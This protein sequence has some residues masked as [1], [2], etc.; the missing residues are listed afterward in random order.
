MPIVAA[1]ALPHPPILVPEVGRGEEEKA[2]ATT[3]AFEKAAL[4]IRDLKPDTIVFVSPHAVCYGDYFHISPGETAWGSLGEFRAPQ[5]R[6]QMEYDAAFAARLARRCERAGIPAGPLGQRDQALDHGV[7]VPLYFIRKAY[8]GFKLVRIGL[9]GLSPL[10]HYRLGEELA[11]TAQEE[12]KRVVLIASGDLSHKFSMESPYGFSPQGPEFD[13]IVMDAFREGDFLAL[14]ELPPALAEEAAECGLRSFQIMAGAL[15]GKKI[16]SQVYSHEG[17]FGIGYG[18]AAFIP[19]GDDPGRRF[20][21]QFEKRNRDRLALQKSKEDAFVRLARAGLETFVQTGHPLP[22][23]KDLG[24]G[25]MDQTGGV[26]VSLK[27]FGRLRGCIGTTGPTTSSLGEEIL[28]NAVSAGTQ[29][30][31]FD[32]VAPE[33]LETLTYSVDVLGPLEK[34]D[35]PAALDPA[36]YGVVVQS[37]SRRGLLLPALAGVDTVEEQVAI[38]KQKAGIGKD[39]PVTLFRFRVVRHT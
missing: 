26:F 7:M 17:P 27:A 32:P 10:I 15:D 29:D 35:S 18:A 34:V 30:P 25:L 13:Q 33:E 36:Q 23:P 9:S 39:A 11:G 20:G 28:Q 22:L 24:S 2:A 19:A 16:Q 38:A 21:E 37:G 14:L 1:F 6:F 5:V 3:A 31:R 8:A 12:N 4:A